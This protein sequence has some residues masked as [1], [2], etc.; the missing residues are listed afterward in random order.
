MLDLLSC[1]CFFGL[2][3]LKVGGLYQFQVFS[4]MF[5]EYPTS[6]ICLSDKKTKEVLVRAGGFVLGFVE[7]R[8]DEQ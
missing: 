1:Y 4:E 8:M 2:L 7:V 6:M 3:P 5:W